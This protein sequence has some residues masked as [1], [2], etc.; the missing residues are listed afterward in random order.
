MNFDQPLPW[1]ADEY[2]AMGETKGR[3][4]LMAGSLWFGPRPDNAH[5]DVTCNLLGMLRASARANGLR[6]LRSAKLRLGP[7]CVVLPDLVAARCDR[8]AEFVTGAEVVLVGEV[9]GVT[10]AANDRCLKRDIYAEAG[11]PWY[12]LVEPSLPDHTSVTVRLLRL[13]GD[14]YVKDAAADLGEVLKSEDPFPFELHTD[15]LLDF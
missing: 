5:Q 12:L 4:E 3:V 6:A 14:H 10:T 7:E 15:D 13:A 1:T 8:R 11:I 9:T 2:L